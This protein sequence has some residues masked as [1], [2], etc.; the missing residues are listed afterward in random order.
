MGA[1]VARAQA[2]TRFAVTCLA[3]F[4]TIALLLAAVGLYGTLA[5]VVRQRTA[6]IGMR[7]ALG[8]GAGE[9]LR[10]VMGQG[11]VLAGVGIAIGFAAA[12]A[13]TRVLG[14][15]LVGVAPT[16]PATHAAAALALL[17]VAAIACWIPARRAA[18]LQPAAAL[19]DDAAPTPSETSAPRA[20][21]TR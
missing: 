20:P 1:A 19:R 6:E 10:A 13:L 4:A 3:L 11:L 15:L 16:D 17:A 9:I 8:A 5:T 21:R 18:R 2:S 14:S 12:L 7:M